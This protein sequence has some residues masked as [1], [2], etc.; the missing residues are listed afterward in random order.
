MSD[1]QLTQKPA[2]VLQYGVLP[3]AEQFASLVQPAT[4]R[5]VAVLHVSPMPQF[6]ADRHSTQ[7]CDGEQYGFCALHCESLTHATQVC[8]AVSQWLRPPPPQFASARHWTHD[9]DVVSQYGVGCPHWPELA[10]LVAMPALPP[11]AAPAVPAVAP[12]PAAFPE[13]PEAVPVPATELPPEPFIAP[14]V[15]PLPPTATLP[16]L[17]PVAGVA[18]PPPAP[19]AVPP[20][21]VAVPPVLIELPPLL[22]ELP[23]LLEFVPPVALL[24]PPVDAPAS[25]LPPLDEAPVPAAAPLPGGLPTE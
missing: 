9:I 23:P 16:E 25:E 3:V 8:V 14:P 11:A 6:A 4:Q 22:I 20:V 1:R 17:P 21:F 19:V 24:E 15:A 13:P 18:P 12:A 2:V 5:N 7:L 10:Q